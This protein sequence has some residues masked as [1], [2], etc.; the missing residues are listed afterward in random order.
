MRKQFLITALVALCVS[1]AP[2]AQDVLVINGDYMNAP[3]IKIEVEDIQEIE[4]RSNYSPLCPVPEAID[5]GLPSGTKWASWNVGASSPEEY[6]GFYA[7]GETEYFNESTYAYYDSAEEE[8]VHIG[9]DIAGTEYDVAHVKWGSSWRMP[10][11]SQIK[12]LIKY[13]EFTWQVKNGKIGTLVTGLNGATIFLP[14][15]GELIPSF[16]AF[17]GGGYY[18]SSEL[19]WPYGDE[20][21]NEAYKLQIDDNLYECSDKNGWSYLTSG[22]RNSGYSVRAVHL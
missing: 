10:T 2:H 17:H 6:G 7:W 4:L 22:W 19:C 15:A 21:D 9:D 1:F 14:A 13:C 20:E 8:Y 5:L 16:G 12:E 3:S 11:V 18:W